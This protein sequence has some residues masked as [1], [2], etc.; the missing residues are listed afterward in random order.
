MGTNEHL[1]GEKHAPERTCVLTREAGPRDRLV[2]LA[3]GPDGRVLPDVRAKAPGRGAYVGVSRPELE[4]AQAKGKLKGALARAFKTGQID[5][6]DDLGERIET[7]LAR[8]VLDRL[9]LEA[10]GGMLLSGAEKVDVA[11]RKGEAMLLL[12]A[13]DASPDGIA[14]L[15]Q[16]WRMGGGA[17][18]GRNGGLVLPFD[19]TTLS[20]ALGRG[21]AVHIAL[22]D[23]GA[24]RRVSH[25]L[26]RYQAF[27]GKH[28][29]VDRHD[30]GG[31]E[32]V[33]TED[34]RTKD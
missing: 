27:L 1:L 5:L 30:A 25:A 31:T 11:C 29:K 13:A 19:R 10:R 12:H 24:A 18:R 3:L 9:G 20:T 21:N 7:A 32:P 34:L 26:A 8:A 28:A 14:K 4:A 17:A 16:G 6:P 33:T 15:A 2:R 23:A 22:V